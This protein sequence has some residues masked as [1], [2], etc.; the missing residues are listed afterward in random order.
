MLSYI[1]F[2]TGTEYKDILLSLHSYL[3]IIISDMF[4]DTKDSSG[5]LF[6]YMINVIDF[7]LLLASLN[8]WIWTSLQVSKM[9]VKRQQDY[10]SQCSVVILGDARVGKSSLL[11]RALTNKFSEVSKFFKLSLHYLYHLQVFLGKKIRGIEKF[12]KNQKIQKI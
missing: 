10:S 1:I 9:G 7:Q 6:A 3:S 12:E 11:N 5:L 2:P 8:S 4:F